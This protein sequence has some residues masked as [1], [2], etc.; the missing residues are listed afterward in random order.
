MDLVF[1]FF[2]IIGVFGGYIV[3]YLVMLFGCV[4]DGCFGSLIGREVFCLIGFG[5]IE[6]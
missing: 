3:V 4:G 5:M 1:V 6:Y 2:E